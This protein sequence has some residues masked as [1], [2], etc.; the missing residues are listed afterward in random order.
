MKKDSLGGN[1]MKSILIIDTPKCCFDC[2]LFREGIVDTCFPIDRD[3]HD[4]E[5]G[6]DEGGN[7]PLWCPLKPLPQEREFGKQNI[8]PIKVDGNSFVLGWNACLKEITE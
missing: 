7:R 6:F 4:E 8:M 1:R 2:R 5:G 3:I